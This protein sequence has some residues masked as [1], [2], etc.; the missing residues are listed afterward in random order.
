MLL[1][2]YE[3]SLINSKIMAPLGFEPSSAL[4][5]HEL[6]LPSSITDQTPLSSGCF[7]SYMKELMNFSFN[8][9]NNPLAI[10]R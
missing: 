9:N 2:P 5:L 8:E 1:R 4:I 6:D 10:C 3:Q 7:I